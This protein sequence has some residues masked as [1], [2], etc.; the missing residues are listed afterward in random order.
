M[1]YP[2]EERNTDHL[3]G[4]LKNG[5][6]YAYLNDFLSSVF[7]LDRNYPK[8]DQKEQARWMTKLLSFLDQNMKRSLLLKIIGEENYIFFVRV[9]GFRTGDED[10]DLQYFSNSLG[11]PTKNIDYANGLFN[12]Y[13]AK[14]RISPIELDRSQGSFR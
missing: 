11:D 1:N 2:Y 10:G 5:N 3:A 4:T 7:Y 9:N 14:T 6:Y 13:A 12:Y 8:T